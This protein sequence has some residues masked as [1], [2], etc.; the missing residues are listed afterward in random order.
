MKI[1][2]LRFKKKVQALQKIISF[3]EIIAHVKRFGF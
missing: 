3:G 2:D 1:I